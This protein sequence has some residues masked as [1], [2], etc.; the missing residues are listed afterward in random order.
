MS[1]LHA[2]LTATAV[3]AALSVQTGCDS[4]PPA[5]ASVEPLASATDNTA[6]AARPGASS[7]AAGNGET[8][9]CPHPGNAAAQPERPRDPRAPVATRTDGTRVFGREGALTSSVALPE[10]LGEPSRFAGQTVKTT[11]VVRQ[12]CQRMGCWMELAAEGSQ[13]RPVFVR[14]AGHAFLLP[15][16]VVGRRATAEG[17]IA[18]RPLS[19]NEIAH[20]N[21]EGASLA[22]GATTVELEATT[23]EILPASDARPAEG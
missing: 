6:A 18:V 13:A 15:R 5:R 12:V 20:Y 1:R 9:S 3:L 23:V 4:A 16:D 2:V 22:E 8:W 14:M 17:R 21:S 7:A 19:P 11:G 10:I